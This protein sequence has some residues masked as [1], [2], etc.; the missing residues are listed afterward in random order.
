MISDKLSLANQDFSRR[1]PGESGR[2]QPIHTFYGGAQLFRAD[3]CR[4]LGTLA[5]RAL[6]DNAPDPATLARAVGIPEALAETVYTRVVEKLR[7][8]AVENFHIDFEDGYGMR[9]NDEEDATAQDAAEQVAVAMGDAGLPA[10]LGLRIKPLN[11]EWKARAFRTLALFLDTLL[12]RTGGR[13]PRNFVVTLPKITVP[14]QVSALADALERFPGI[15]ME[16]MVETPQ[17]VLLLP[18][19]LEAAHGLCTA[20]HFGV[21]DYTAS[22]GITAALQHL[23]HPAG[24][25]ARSMMQIHLAGTG[26]WPVDGGTNVLPLPGRPDSVERAWKLHYDG[27]RHALERGFYQ[28]WDLHPAQLPTRYAAVYSFFLEGREAASKRLRNFI[29]QAAR[30]TEVGGVF[31]DA[32]TGQGLLNYFLRAANCGAIPESDLP[33]LTGLTIEQ[34]RS[35]SCFRGMP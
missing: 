16:L 30:A 4:K 2:R 7:R 20:V 25:F 6:R 33:A 9:P 28:G 22:L 35:G 26:I 32:A 15:N 29:A 27:V 19:L 34:L 18:Q 3:T 12:S 13:L 24:D 31:D 5:E 8:E 1:Y 14:E 11:E 23:M 17:S 10:F 21:Y